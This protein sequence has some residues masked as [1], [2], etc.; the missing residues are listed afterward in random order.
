MKLGRPRGFVNGP[1]ETS[2]SL[3][4]NVIG[5][6]TGSPTRRLVLP[7][8]NSASGKSSIAAGLRED[9]R[10]RTH[11]YYLDVPFVC[12]GAGA[13][14]AQTDRISSSSSG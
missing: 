6:L 11:A 12:D 1:D 7:R 13:R 4:G 8:G 10:G 9:H 3:A 5:V 14:S 2:R